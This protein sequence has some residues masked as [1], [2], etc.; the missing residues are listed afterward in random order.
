MEMNGEGDPLSWAR[1]A[2]ALAGTHLQ[3]VV[4]KDV[5]LI[6]AQVA[7]VARKAAVT[8]LLD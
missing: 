7:A 2:K 5:T 3:E 1:A 8:I 6:V 4:T